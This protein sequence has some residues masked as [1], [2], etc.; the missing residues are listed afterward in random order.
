MAPS[1]PLYQSLKKLGYSRIIGVDE[2]GRGAL[3]GP[4][5]VAAVEIDERIFG[6]DDSKLLT[7]VKRE[8]LNTD[9]RR[10]ARQLQIGQASNQEIDSLG[11]SAALRLAYNRA[12]ENIYAD[13][14]LTDFFNLESLPYITAAK[15]D[16]L[17]YPVAA[18][19]IVAKVYRDNLMKKLH[20][21]FPDYGWADNAGYGTVRHRAKI[22]E[23]GPCEW[24][25]LTWLGGEKARER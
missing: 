12:L 16:Q 11:V 2:V 3:A 23:I 20:Q 9:I 8:S 4:M 6:V 14:V 19:S 25:R 22:K 24:H 7:A 18:A 15:G 13:L 17:F 1:W 10:A 21:K 5:V